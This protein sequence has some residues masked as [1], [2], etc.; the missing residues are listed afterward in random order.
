MSGISSPRTIGR[1][2]PR[3]ALAWAAVLLLWPAAGLGQGRWID[4][5]ASQSY[6][7]AVEGDPLSFELFPPMAFGPFGPGNLVYVDLLRW[8]CAS[9]PDV[10]LCNTGRLL[11]T[12]Y[13]FLQTGA[14]P[15]Q[16]QLVEPVTVQVHYDPARVLELGGREVDLSLRHYDEDRQAWV[17]LGSQTLDTAQDLIAGRHAGNARQYY[18]LV[19]SESPRDQATWGRI[20]GHWSGS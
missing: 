15:C 13:G 9:L 20:K 5:G 14:C 1:L 8:P 7:I 17:E 6:Q 16:G 3:H 19:L 18:A 2:S 4:I 11:G 12:Y 10:T